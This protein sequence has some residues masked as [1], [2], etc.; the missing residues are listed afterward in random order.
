MDHI[1]LDFRKIFYVIYVS[2]NKYNLIQLV[3]TL[4][5]ALSFYMYVLNINIYV[6]LS[7]QP[8]ILMYS[9]NGCLLKKLNPLVML[10]ALI[11]QLYTY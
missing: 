7:I 8:R 6:Y 9:W 1:S 5:S 4:C 2:T 10:L 11:L 3:E